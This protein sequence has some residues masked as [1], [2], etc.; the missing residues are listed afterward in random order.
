VKAVPTLHECPACKLPVQAGESDF[1]LAWHDCDWVLQRERE[2]L[3]E[4]P[5]P[6][7]IEE[8]ER[9][10]IAAVM[11]KV[12]DPQTTPRD[13]ALMI[14]SLAGLKGKSGGKAQDLGG[15]GNALNEWMGRR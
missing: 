11:R 5:L 4:E 7:S 6:E 8:A 10:L 3:P 12:R 13:V 15:K 1:G 2:M 9:E 14:D